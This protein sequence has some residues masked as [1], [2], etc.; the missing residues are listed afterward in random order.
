MVIHSKTEDINGKIR[1]E[2][3]FM[4][5]INSEHLKLKFYNLGS[6]VSDFFGKDEVEVTY[7]IYGK[8]VP[9]VYWKLIRRKFTFNNSTTSNEIKKI[10]NELDLFHTIDVW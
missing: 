8:N 5:K 10:C 9:K 2:I 6:D 1:D 7:S 4:E 3:L